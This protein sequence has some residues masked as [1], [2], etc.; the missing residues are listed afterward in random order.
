VGRSRALVVAFVVASCTLTKTKV[1]DCTSSADCRDAF[2]AG[3]VCDSGGLCQRV[4]P[5]ARCT[6]TFPVDVLSR[7]ESY[8]GVF[9]IGVLMDRSVETQRMRE[10]AVRL[11]LKQVNEARGIDG[12]TFGAVFCDIAENAMYDARKR[13]DAAVESARHLARGIGVPAIV[14]PSSSVDALAV[15]NELRNDGVLVISPAATSPAI[16][17]VDTNQ[18]TDERPGLFWRTAPPDTEQGAAIVRFLTQPTPPPPTRVALI[19]ERGAYGDGLANV[20]RTGFETGG[21]TVAITP[22]ANTSERDAAIVNAGA[23]GVPWVLFFSSQTTDSIAFLNAANGLASYASV[24]V[25][26]TDSAANR[27]LL[28]GAAG[29]GAIFPRVAGS[30][31]QVPQGPTFELFRASFQ[32]EFK[33]DPNAFSFVSHSYDAAWLVFYGASSSFR[34]EGRVTGSGIARGLRRITATGEEVQVTPVNWTRIADALTAGKPVNLVGASGGL[35]YD[36]TEETS[37]LVEIWGIASN[38]QTIEVRATID[39][40]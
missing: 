34:R 15:W 27:D 10:N 36:A 32:A 5:E 4:K 20:F 9:L 30:R 24:N 12:R 25:F 33:V 17:G 37:S 6:T 22:F 40:R 14:G 26:L 31:P 23:A 16:T 35:N 1:D 19:H 18:P 3:F 2:G 39:P 7:P 11:A 29:A 8:P 38:G 28:T 21:R 13:T